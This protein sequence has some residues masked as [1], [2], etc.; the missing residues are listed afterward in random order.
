[1]PRYIHKLIISLIVTSAN[2]YSD[3]KVHKIMSLVLCTFS[4]KKASPERPA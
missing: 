3:I 4:K 1:L 2:N